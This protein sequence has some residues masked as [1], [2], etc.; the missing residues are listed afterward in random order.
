MPSKLTKKEP[1]K[2]V[3]KKKKPTQKKKTTREDKIDSVAVKSSRLVDVTAE[4]FALMKEIFV[5]S[6]RIA[7]VILGE[8]IPSFEDDAVLLKSI[9][10]TI[11]SSNTLAEQTIRILM[12]TKDYL[13]NQ[14]NGA[15]L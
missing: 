6:N 14:L 11:N 13:E 8:K 5:M 15:R 12:D 1:V 7:A 10:D 9:T 3:P 4:N 2:E